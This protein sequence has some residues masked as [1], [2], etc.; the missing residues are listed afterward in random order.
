MKEVTTKAVCRALA[1]RRRR[2]GISQDAL[3]DIAG[4]H[5]KV[6]SHIEL[7][8]SNN[9]GIHT[10]SKIAQGLGM[11][12]SELYRSVEDGDGPFRGKG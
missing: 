2:L 3:A 12:L 6:I 5:Q 9:P 7:G 8:K 11:R 10:I 4:T 1:R